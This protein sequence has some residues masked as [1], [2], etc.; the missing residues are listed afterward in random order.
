MEKPWTYS[1]T[2]LALWKLCKRRYYNQ[3]VLGK[4]EPKTVNMAAGAWLAQNPIEDWEK[5]KREG[6]DL[7]TLDSSG[8]QAIWANFLAEFGG[9][10]TFDDP[11][12]TIALAKK[13]LTA[14]KANPV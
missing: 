2:Q 9:D 1:H 4:K 7:N 6:V 5:C 8:W 3:Y 12:F 13:I 10:D 11:I 14:Y